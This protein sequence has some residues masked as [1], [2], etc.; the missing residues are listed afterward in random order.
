M[1]NKNNVL[2]DFKKWAQ[3]AG[4]KKRFYLHLIRHSVATEYLRSS[5]DVESLRKILGHADLR[6]VLIYSHLADSTIQE[7]HQ[8]HGFFGNEN[9]IQRKRSNKRKK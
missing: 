8:S 4:I 3:E 9:V 7:K 2:R 5:G 6:T 1:L